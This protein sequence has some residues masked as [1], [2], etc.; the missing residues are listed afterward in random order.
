MS[1]NICSWMSLHLPPRRGK[2]SPFCH[3]GAQNSL[4]M[5]NNAAHVGDFNLK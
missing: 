2:L 4:A 5:G 3:A 1:D